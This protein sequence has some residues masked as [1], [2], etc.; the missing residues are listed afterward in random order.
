V[1]HKQLVHS[2][3]QA[4]LALAELEF[5]LLLLEPAL[6]EVAVADRLGITEELQLLLVVMEVAV[7]A[8]L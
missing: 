5:H 6:H 2:Q 1:E 8:L 7:L 4:L 3:H